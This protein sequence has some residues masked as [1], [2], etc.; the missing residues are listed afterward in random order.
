VIQFEGVWKEYQHRKFR[1]LVLRDVNFVLNRG[2]SL[3]VCGANGAGKSTLIRLIAGV[4]HASLGHIRRR[5]STSW[6]LGYSSAFQ[7]SLTGAD[8]VRFIA[9]I[10]GKPV[11]ELLHYVED[12]AVLGPFLRQPIATYSAGMQARLAFAVS[13]AV[14]FDCYLIDEITGA[15]DERFRIRFEDALMERRQRSSLVMVSHASEALR[16][17]CNRGAVLFDGQLSLYDTIDEAIEVH[18]TRQAR[19]HR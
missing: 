12:F 18:E 4:E 7:S 3:G 14:D 6:P 15:G 11:E 9:R 13:L 5:M 1:K 8:N 10:Y 2:E 19:L 17:Y 16:T